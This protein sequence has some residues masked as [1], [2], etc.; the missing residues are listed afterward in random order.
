SARGYTENE[1]G[2]NY[3]KDFHEQT[4]HLEGARF[5]F[6]DGHGSHCTL[7]FLKFAESHDIIVLSTPPHTTHELQGLDVACFGVLKIYWEQECHEH[8]RNTGKAVNNDTFL[9]V[10][11][12]AQAR[13]F[14]D[15]TI[16]SAYRTTGIIPFRREAALRP[17]AMAPALDTSV[18]G[19]FPNPLPSPVRA[20]IDAH[21]KRKATVR[22]TAVPALEIVAELDESADEAVGTG[23]DES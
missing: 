6:V 8:F 11:S 18:K 23:G 9:L 16:R 20:I 17:D 12:R 7:E 10:Y 19:Q 2:V 1:I 4:K 14:K 5:L 13:T 22:G 3:I 21:Q 15:P